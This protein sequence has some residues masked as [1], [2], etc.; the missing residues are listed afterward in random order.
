MLKF[1]DIFVMADA[2]STEKVEE[3]SFYS[4]WQTI[5]LSEV[6]SIQLVFFINVDNHFC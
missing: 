4:S 6:T 5:K 1:T 3:D 2:N